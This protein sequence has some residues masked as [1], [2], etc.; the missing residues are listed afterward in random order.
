MMRRGLVWALT[1]AMALPAQGATSRLVGGIRGALGGNPSARQPIILPGVLAVG[2]WAATAQ[3]ANQGSNADYGYNDDT[4]AAWDVVPNQTYTGTNQLCVAAFHAPTAAQYATGI[5]N[6]IAKVSFAINGGTF[7]DVVTPTTNPV[8]GQLEYCASFRSSDFSFDGQFEARAIAYPITGI[9]LVLQSFAGSSV[10]VT[11]ILANIDRTGSALPHTATY[12]ATTGNDTGNCQSVSSPCATIDY[13]AGQI[14]TAQSSDVGGGSINLSAGTYVLGAASE[15]TARTAATQWI[16]VQAKSGVSPSSVIINAQGSNDGIRTNKLRLYNLTVNLTGAFVSGGLVGLGATS[17]A[18]WTD[19]VTITGAGKG[20]AVGA[21]FATTTWSRIYVTNTDIGYIANG[22][23]NSTLV[24][25]VTVHDILSDAFQGSFVVIGSS[26]SSENPTYTANGALTLNV[27]TT[28][29]G[30]TTVT[31]VTDTSQL[32]VGFSLSGTGIPANTTVTSVGAGQITI[33]NAATASGTIT[34]QSGAHP[35]VYQF[36]GATTNATASGATVTITGSLS[37]VNVGSPA[38]GTNIPAF[39]YIT[40][41][42]GSIATLNAPTTGS[43]TSITTS[44]SNIVL[45]GITGNY[46]VNAQGWFGGANI[47]DMVLA[48]SNISYL[49][50]GMLPTPGGY[51]MQAGGSTDNLLM[52]GTYFGGNAAWRTDTSFTGHDVTMVNMVCSSGTMGN[53]SASGVTYY[54]GT[55]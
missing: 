3:P 21:P 10:S 7:V 13:A 32:G 44:H 35:D 4:I 33:S 11:S 6:N 38:V 51:I 14:Y 41:L 50:P 40:A 37:N 23:A 12:V 25:G 1:F 47:R 2:S 8:S 16:T 15:P 36:I 28:S 30:S 31:G 27:G 39:D 20:V 17:P 5:T 48:N 55:C 53:H 49:T 45:Y 19:H 54:G 34:L 42:S 24:S 46:Y 18:I 22:P 29:T 52:I 9:P 26:S 43:I